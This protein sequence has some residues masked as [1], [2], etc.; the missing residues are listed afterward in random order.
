MKQPQREPEALSSLLLPW[1]DLSSGLFVAC[2]CPHPLSSTPV[3]C[4]LILSRDRCIHMT[5]SSFEFWKRKGWSCWLTK[6]LPPSHK[7]INKYDAPLR[8]EAFKIATFTVDDRTCDS[9]VMCGPC[10]RL[11]ASHHTQSTTY[12]R[13][14]KSNVVTSRCELLTSVSFSG[15]HTGTR[16]C[17]YTLRRPLGHALGYTHT[18]TH[19]ESITDTH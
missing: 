10:D 6:N 18:H 12:C 19:T 15:S 9:K 16:A 13:A 1:L 5:N 11:G 7:K 8:R 17:W 3:S 14:L 2:H 4:L